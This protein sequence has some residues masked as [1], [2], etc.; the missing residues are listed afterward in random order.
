MTNKERNIQRL[1]NEEL[2]QIKER[3][4]K[5]TGGP[6]KCADTTDGAWLLDDADLIVA[7]TFGR[8]EDASFTAHAREDIPKLTAEIER[9]RHAISWG[10]SCVGCS[11]QLAEEWEIVNGA[12]VC[13]DCFDYGGDGE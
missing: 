8:E 2:A 5:A 11:N 13:R 9:L 10:V 1:T 12:F 7:E 3:A 4:E 6:W